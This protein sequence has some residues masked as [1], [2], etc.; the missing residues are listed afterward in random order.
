MYLQVEPQPQPMASV[1]APP[2]PVTITE[3][4]DLAT[5]DPL[6]VAQEIAILRRSQAHTEARLS[7]LLELLSSLYIEGVVPKV[8]DASGFTFQLIAGRVSYQWAGIPEVKAVEQQLKQL[9]ADLQ[10]AGSVPS[11]TG[12][13]YWRL[14]AAAPEAH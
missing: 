10:A 1:Q 8:F 7:E 14:A 12:A 9:K 13:A 11:T 6:A 3:P 4:V 2:I 5:V